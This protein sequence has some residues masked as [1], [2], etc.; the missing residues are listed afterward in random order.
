MTL[1][2]GF[3]AYNHPCLESS[4]GFS[5]GPSCF[6]LTPD[7]ALH[8]GRAAPRGPRA[9]TLPTPQ[10]GNDSAQPDFQV[11][12]WN[13]GALENLITK[14]PQTTTTANSESALGTR[15]SSKDSIHLT[16]TSNTVE[17]LLSPPV[18]KQSLGLPPTLP[19]PRICTGTRQLPHCPLEDPGTWAVV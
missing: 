1:C 7:L 4:W 19:C 10:P 16:F 18:W 15:H 13:V 6:E 17:M 12:P 2:Q 5:S 9:A 3:P 8:M 14:Q 11:G